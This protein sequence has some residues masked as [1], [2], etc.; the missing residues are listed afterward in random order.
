[1]PRQQKNPCSEFARTLTELAMNV[2]SRPDV[3]NLND[4]LAIIQKDLP[5]VDRAILADSITAATSGY[6]QAQDALKT[7]L[8]EMKREAR[9]DAALRRAIVKLEGHVNAGTRPAPTPKKAAPKDI[10]ALRDRLGGLREQLRENDPARRKAAQDRIAELEKHLADGTVPAPKPRKATPADLQDLR[11]QANDLRRQVMKA[12]PKA[13]EAL[14]ERIREINKH[15]TDGTYPAPQSKAPAPADIQAL[16]D[17]LATARA[18]LR[19]Q[20][21]KIR[22]ELRRQIAELQGHLDAGTLPPRTPQERADVPDDVRDLREARDELDAALAKSEPALR[23]KFQSQIDDL[24]ERIENGVQPPAARVDPVLSKELEQMKYQRDMLKARVRREIEALKPKTIWGKTWTAVAEPFNALRAI[25]T[26]LDFSAVL[27]QGGFI[28]LGN[29]ARAARALKPMF[30]AF[31]DPAKSH[32]IN[33]EI[34]NRD[35]AYLYKR[36]G[37]YIAP[38]G[39]ASSLASKEEAYMSKWVEKIP[40]IAGSQRAYVTFLNKLRADSFDAMVNTLAIDGNA[41]DAEMKAIAT[42]VNVATGRGNMGQTMEKAAPLLNTVFFAP[43]YVASRFQLLLGAPALGGTARTR[44]LVAKEYAKFLGGLGVVYLLG[45]LAGGE[46]EKDPA[47]SDFGKIRFGNTR[48]DPLAGMAQAATFIGRQ[49]SGAKVDMRGKVQELD[50]KGKYNTR[51]AVAQDFTRSKMSP[52]AGAVYDFAYNEGPDRKPF[53]AVKTAKNLV[54][55]MQAESLYE[56]F[57][58]QGIPR[59]TALAILSVFGMGVNTYSK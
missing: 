28:A 44:K 17:E 42:Y 10:Q 1:M 8:N 18:E 46:I 30:Q 6:V 9:G 54:L 29:P 41:T 50:G 35:N 43:R 55:P 38:D 52:V 20:D 3:Q 22:Q 36:A 49:I 7:K 14:R 5:N 53:S 19:K 11:N 34:L 39:E 12:D 31:A 40:G 13:R 47:S 45:A 2:G 27:R 56:A 59:G 51:G 48:L 16:R 26:S 24:L 33:Q 58:D 21:P 4:V 23:E 37:L 57:Q 15:L 25:M 32:A